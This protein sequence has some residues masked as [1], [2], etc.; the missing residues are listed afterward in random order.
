MNEQT[1]CKQLHRK[2]S[3]NGWAL[4]IY[5][6]VMNLAVS[7]VCILEVA[8]RLI[9]SA[10]EVAFDELLI[11][12]LMSNGWGY[13]LTVLIGLVGAFIWK[14]RDFCRREIWRTEKPMTIRS[15]LC[16]LC[17]F[18]SAQVFFQ[19]L[20]IVLELLL[21]QVGI[22]VLDSME[23]AT[24]TADSFSMFLYMTLL[25]PVTE[26]IFFRGVILRSLEPYGKKF[27][28]LGSAFLF[29]IFHGN[30]VQSPYAFVVGLVLG[31]VTVEYSIGWAMVLHMFNNLVL[32][33]MLTRITMGLPGWVGETLSFAVIW[34]FAIAAI[35]IL[36]C[37]R[38]D[39]AAYFRNG[40]MHPWCV[41]SFF[42][43]PGVIV[44]SIYMSINM[45]LPLIM[46]LFA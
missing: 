3:P 21:N 34:G 37:K 33:D 30:I 41:K 19:I 40:R 11:D 8:F 20:S 12:V 44:L 1:V 43:S 22:S 46:Q 39:I 27:A 45:L 13:V 32:G 15:F 26:E 36:V 24:M 7:A 4:L 17:V 6:L 29:G 35:V 14:G 9:I 31:Y 23:T 25:A 42:Y 18:M 38:K 5:H 28:I 16:L 2:F 10:D